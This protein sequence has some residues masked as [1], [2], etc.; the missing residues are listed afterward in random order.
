MIYLNKNIYLDLLDSNW[1]KITKKNISEITRITGGADV[2]LFVT[3]GIYNYMILIK[4]FSIIFCL[5]LFLIFVNFQA[6]LIISIIFCF[7]VY[8]C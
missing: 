3:Q 4:N 5:S 6:T 1:D 7:Y 2:M 8:I